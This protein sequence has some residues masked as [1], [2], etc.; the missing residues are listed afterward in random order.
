MLQDCCKIFV[1]CL[2]PPQK[3]D[4]Q[5]ILGIED[6]TRLLPEHYFLLDES[7]GKS[8]EDKIVEITSVDADLFSQC[9]VPPTAVPA[10]F[11]VLIGRIQPLHRTAR[12]GKFEIA[13][14]VNGIGPLVIDPATVITDASVPKDLQNTSA[15]TF[16]NMNENRLVLMLPRA[17][18]DSIDRPDEKSTAVLNPAM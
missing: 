1:E 8:G 5:V 7:R 6:E 9:S 3:I 11:K 17:H 12:E 15:R 2:N 4:F 10:S 18:R 13:G 14:E 16:W